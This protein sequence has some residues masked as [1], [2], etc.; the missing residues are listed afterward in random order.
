MGCHPEGIGPPVQPGCA[1]GTASSDELWN[2]QTTK[3]KK[4]KQKATIFFHH[5]QNR[6][7]LSRLSHFC[8]SIVPVITFIRTKA[9][10]INLQSLVSPKWTRQQGYYYRAVRFGLVVWSVLCCV[11]T[12]SC[13]IHD[14]HCNQSLGGIKN[15]LVSLLDTFYIIYVI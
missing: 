7:L 9:G 13:R 11:Y 15:V 12:L 8:F 1:S 2:D 5:T 4:H 14:L 10:G 6:S 3:L